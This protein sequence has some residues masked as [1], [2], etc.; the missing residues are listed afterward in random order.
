MNNRISRFSFPTTIYFGPGAI[1]NL[2]EYVQDLGIKKP[3][4]VTDPGLLKT[5]VFPKVEEILKD[6]GIEFSVV[7]EINPNPLDSDITKAA[8]S[9]ALAE[10]ALWMQPK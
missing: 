8:A 5:D 4:I 3:L 9:S 10:E 2:P 1:D 7:S 6:A